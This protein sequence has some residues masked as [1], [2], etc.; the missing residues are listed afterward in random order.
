MVSNLS[1]QVLNPNLANYDP[2]VLD[3]IRKNTNNYNEIQKQA[4]QELNNYPSYNQI[5]YEPENDTFINSTNNNSNNNLELQNQPTEGFY[6][7][8]NQLSSNKRNTNKQDYQKTAVSITLG[9]IL[10]TGV[11]L[12][13]LGKIRSKWLSDIDITNTPGKD[14]SFKDKFKFHIAKAGD[15]INEIFSSGKKNVSKTNVPVQDNHRMP[16][17]L[18][19]NIN[20]PQNSLSYNFVE[21]LDQ[22]VRKIGKDDYDNL[23]LTLDSKALKHLS[24]KKIN[25]ISKDSDVLPD[26]FKVIENCETTIYAEV[27]P[28]G[29]NIEIS[30]LKENFNIAKSDNYK[31][32]IEINGEEYIGKYIKKDG[33]DRFFIKI[34]GSDDLKRLAQR[35][36]YKNLKSNVQDAKT[37]LKGLEN[38]SNLNHKN[39]Q[40]QK[41][42]EKEPGKYLVTYTHTNGVATAVVLRRQDINTGKFY[43]QVKSVKVDNLNYPISDLSLQCIKYKDGYKPKILS[44]DDF[45]GK[46]DNDIIFE[47]KRY[48]KIH[49]GSGIE[50]NPQGFKINKTQN[51]AVSNL[52]AVS[53]GSRIRK[54]AKAHYFLGTNDKYHLYVR[55]DDL[56]PRAKLDVFASQFMF[57]NDAQKVNLVDQFLST[58]QLY[59]KKGNFNKAIGCS[60]EEFKK[61][62]LIPYLARTV[63]EKDVRKY[64]LKFKN[65]DFYFDRHANTVFY[66]ID[67]KQDGKIA[68]VDFMKVSPKEP[69]DTNLGDKIKLLF[70]SCFSEKSPNGITYAKS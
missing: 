66:K 53:N 42:V 29:H 15:K 8:Y 13:S 26:V 34:G 38:F 61:L 1:N 19:N 14:V 18:S 60:E 69:K 43:S 65:K 52:G 31:A 70:K 17:N 11:T 47:G 51:H 12:F 56:K 30:K 2:A 41:V 24:S 55:Y 20:L 62:F 48:I 63:D 44:E 3:E 6:S 64:S 39:I 35:Q 59:D 58:H 37:I 33:Q 32:S 46:Y 57:S 21:N 10:L 50:S 22:D 27:N 49:K 16:K 9:A 5:A 4:S 7:D 45:V 36:D 28:S 40:I 68:K 25:T 23:L 54:D 67:G